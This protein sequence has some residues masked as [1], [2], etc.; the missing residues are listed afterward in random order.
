MS[1]TRT[2]KEACG[3]PIARRNPRR[4]SPRLEILRRPA[5][6]TQTRSQLLLGFA[7]FAAPP[8]H[9]PA[10]QQRVLFQLVFCRGTVASTLS[11]GPCSMRTDAGAIACVS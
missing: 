10:N 9:G 11:T 7:F 1:R 8:R 4:M 2:R 5:S 3:T 6:V